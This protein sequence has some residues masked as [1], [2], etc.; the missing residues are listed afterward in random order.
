VSDETFSLQ[1]V[2]NYRKEMERQ[3]HREFV[4][5]RQALVSAQARLSR[6]IERS[7]QIL[8]ELMEKQGEGIDAS[9]LSLYN[10]FREH[11]KQV[12]SEQRETV[13]LLDRE[14]EQRR[15]LLVEASKEKKVLEKYRD[16]T[17]EILRQEMMIK[18]RKFLDEI[19]LR[20]R[21]GDGR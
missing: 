8:R 19:S 20:R 1:Q 11:Q 3:R 9:E 10:S 17:M 12:I 7:D 4:E 15:T 5:A 21:G 13:D 2:L 16:R 18:E 14:V 6:E